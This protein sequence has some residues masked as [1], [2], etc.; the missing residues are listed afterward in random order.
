[1]FSIQEVMSKTAEQRKE[2]MHCLESVSNEAGW[3]PEDAN[4]YK[5]L[6]TTDQLQIKETLDRL[7]LAEI[8]M[9][10]QTTPHADYLVAT[11]LYD[12]LIYASKKYDL[13]PLISAAMVEPWQGGNLTVTIAKD[14]TYAP[15]KFVGG[16]KLKEIQ[17]S[18]T[19]NTLKPEGYGI[20]I[21]GG[22]DLIEDEQFGIVQWNVMQAAKAVGKRATDIALKTLK[23]GTGGDGT[24]NSHAA[25]S[26]TTVWAG[27]A[28]SDVVSAVLGVA[29]DEFNANTLVATGSAW[30][31]A[32]GNYSG[33]VA[34]H[35]L[36]PLPGYNL[37]VGTLDVLLSN[38][39]DLHDSGDIWPGAAFTKNVT[40]VFDRDNALMTG[41]KRWMEIKNYSDPVNDIGGAVVSFRQANICLYNDSIFV[42]TES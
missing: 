18:F 15:K 26:G 34:W 11:K 29:E 28:G 36:E 33:T 37:K 32:L 9:I 12:T 35:P 42:L 41:R 25:G 20:P 21:L 14:G 23:T 13:C 16:G 22:E 40:L 7:S 30:G 24:V 31:D 3:H 2:I 17:P 6:P 19:Q 8:L 10:G 27:S 5:G 39:P 38:S 1:M 4:I